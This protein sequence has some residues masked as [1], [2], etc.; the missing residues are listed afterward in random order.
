MTLFPL[1]YFLYTAKFISCSL[2]AVQFISVSYWLPNLFLVPYWLANL[3]LVPY[4]LPNLFLF[5]IGWPIYFCLLLAAQF[6]SVSYRLANLFLFPIGCPI[7]FCFLLAVQFI[8]VSFWLPNLFLVPNCRPSLILQKVFLVTACKV[9]TSLLKNKINYYLSYFQKFP[10]FCSSLRTLSS[11][12]LEH[13]RWCL[14][15]LAGSQSSCGWRRRR[16]RWWRSSPWR[17]PHWPNV[18]QINSCGWKQAW[19]PRIR[20]CRLDCIS[21]YKVW[22]R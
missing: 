1:I 5:P 11:A 22:F 2:S 18:F 17:T 14:G 16:G 9:F 3:F 15:C 19:L 6:I 20:A 8:S 12:Y 10:N 21:I 13:W 4:W 7:Y